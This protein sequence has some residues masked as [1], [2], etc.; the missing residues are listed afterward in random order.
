MLGVDKEAALP[1]W[2]PTSCGLFVRR[3]WSQSGEDVSRMRD[4][5]DSEMRNSGESDCGDIGVY[6]D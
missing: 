6:C 1:V 4:T 5:E 3:G 2:P